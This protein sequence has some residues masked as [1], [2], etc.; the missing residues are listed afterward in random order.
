MAKGDLEIDTFR[1][2]L[3]NAI[4]DGVNVWTME[5]AD[6]ISQKAPVSK[7]A[8]GKYG[9]YSGGASTGAR[10]KQWAVRPMGMGPHSSPAYVPKNN[11]D[12]KLQDTLFNAYYQID[13]RNLASEWARS[14]SNL[15]AQVEPRLRRAGTAERIAKRFVYAEGP[16][17]GEVPGKIVMSSRGV[18]KGV[19]GRS[20][21]TLKRSIHHIPASVEGRE[22]VGG[23]IATAPYAAAVEFG[24]KLSGAAAKNKKRGTVAANPFF[25][26]VWNEY[27]V[28]DSLA[29]AI[30]PVSVG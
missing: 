19:G 29:D 7:S 26:P 2:A 14:R 25:R 21:G 10:A 17:A 28:S 13:D 9:S 18:V 24:H 6:A 8:K 11:A 1:E 15:A 12:R 16:R 20:P 30:E 3:I 22:I 5:I 27:A 23:V 4:V